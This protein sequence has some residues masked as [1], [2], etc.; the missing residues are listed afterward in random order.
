MGHLRLNDAIAN[1]VVATSGAQGVF[2]TKLP[3]DS[4][5]SLKPKVFWVN[6]LDDEDQETYYRRCLTLGQ[7]R[8][9]HL[10]VRPG[11]GADIGFEWHTQDQESFKPKVFD[12]HGVPLGWDSSEIMS[13]VTDLGWSNPVALSRKRKGKVSCWR[14][15]STP[16]TEKKDEGSWS[17]SVDDVVPWTLNVL[18]APP[19]NAK[20]VSSWVQAPR[21]TFGQ[22]LAEDSAVLEPAK[23][24]RFGEKQD[25]GKGSQSKSK[26]KD[27]GAASA[28]G[29]SRSPLRTKG[30]DDEEENESKEAR[31]ALGK[32]S[33][34]KKDDE[35]NGLV[36]ATQLDDESP[37]P[38]PLDP[39]SAMQHHHY[40]LSDQGG[41]GDCAFRAICD[42]M[43]WNDKPSAD[44]TFPLED[45]KKKGAWL[46][47]QTINHLRKHKA[48]LLPFFD[49]HYRGKSFD[50]WFAQA[51]ESGYW[52]NGMLLQ[53]IANKLGAA[54][55]IFRREEGSW[56]RF[57]V[58]P[59]FNAAGYACAAQGVAPIVLTLEKNTT[60]ACVCRMARKC[61][62]LG[63][64]K[65]VMCGNP[66]WK[67]GGPTI[68][69]LSVPPLP[70]VP[71]LSIL[72]S[73]RLLLVWSLLCLRP[74][75]P[76][77][78]PRS[79]P[80]L[81]VLIPL[82]VLR[83]RLAM[84][85]RRLCL[86]SLPLFVVL[87]PLLPCRTSPLRFIPWHAPLANP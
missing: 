80:S 18:L 41:C 51:S 67:A 40:S 64:G 9:Q 8:K 20:A 24:A 66:I 61:L 44:A 10:I 69:C 72:W 53:G 38:P 83:C 59:R 63:Y 84:L 28:R 76:S 42:S 49:N 5:T 27:K 71:L 68:R 1:K 37:A 65:V 78:L 77:A 50:D 79:T 6:K 32:G 62:M 52:V 75:D 17:Y 29:R 31:Q 7:T 73:T 39:D 57:C 23:R 25:P 47:A 54:L 85:L 48:E 74:R 19:K 46:R 86:P 56:Q 87:P 13:L 60:K 35:M 34:E 21:R 14:I 55:I 15:R 12:F 45:A 81:V 70:G 43:W 30:S 4:D 33:T 11:G 82:R 36:K 58:A 3:K 22:F 2:C 26:E 16:P